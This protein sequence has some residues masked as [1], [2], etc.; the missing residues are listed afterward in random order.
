MLHIFVYTKVHSS[1][2]CTRLEIE[3]TISTRTEYPFDIP[4]SMFVTVLNSGIRIV[5][6]Q[7]KQIVNAY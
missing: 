3:I 2:L 6:I 1:V 4:I 5:R 7:S